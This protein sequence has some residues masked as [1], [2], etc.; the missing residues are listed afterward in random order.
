M[1]DIISRE[2]FVI[3][4]NQFLSENDSHKLILPLTLK[5]S[6]YPGLG[7]GKVVGCKCFPMFLW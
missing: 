3:K 5:R 4:K 2:D 1:F 6:R 7:V